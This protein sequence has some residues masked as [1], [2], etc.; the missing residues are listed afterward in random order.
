MNGNKEKPKA[1]KPKAKILRPLGYLERYELSMLSLDLYRGNMVTC[2][3]TIPASLLSSPSSSSSPSPN[4]ELLQGTVESGIARLVLAHPFL[5]VGLR[6]ESRRKPDWMSLESVDFRRHVQWHHVPSSAT[7]EEYEREVEG[8]IRGQLDERFLEWGHAHTDGMSA[9]IWHEDLLRNLNELLRNKGTVDPLPELK[10]RILTIPP[11]ALQ[12]LPPLHTLCK[13][14]VSLGYALATL[15]RELKPP[16]LASSSIKSDVT[17]ARW[18]PISV[19][20]YKPQYRQFAL[21]NAELGRV[22]TMCRSKGTTLTGLLQALV[23]ASL[24]CRLTPEE[25][26]GFLGV[27]IVNLRPLIEGEER[28]KK[29]LREVKEKTGESVDLKRM[30]A[31]YMTAMTHEFETQL[32]KDIRARAGSGEEGSASKD[33]IAALDQLVWSTAGRI[34]GEIQAKLDRGLKND[35]LGLVKAVLDFRVLFK[36]MVKKPR[37]H[38]F[39][40]TNLGV[41]DGNP[42][43]GTEVGADREGGWSIDRAIFSVSPEVAGSAFTV[44]PIAVKGGELWVS[45]D[46]QDCAMDAAL[47]DGV[48]ADLEAWLRYFGGISEV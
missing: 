17:S 46:W 34:R 10:D 26:Q 16:A 7:E 5:R 23:M 22:I 42:G 45:C 32:V 11:A 6:G 14:P 35:L 33:R 44:C 1:R 19:K 3:Y 48:T 36:D 39:A 15:W 40:V 13:F 18:S 4:F 24:A 28:A 41:I 31:N 12:L 43:S 20:P 2:Q 25:A 8:F 29:V 47:G 38:S 27:T 9:K 30:M 37:A 21:S